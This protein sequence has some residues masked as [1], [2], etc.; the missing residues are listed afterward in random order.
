MS[1]PHISWLPWFALGATAL[2]TLVHADDCEGSRAMYDQ[3]RSVATTDPGLALRLL[4]TMTTQCP[5]AP[6]GWFL[7]GNMHRERGDHAAARRAYRQA[8][9]VADAPQAVEMARA[10]AALASFELGESCEAQ[11]TFRSLVPHPGEEVSDWLSDPW[12]AFARAMADAELSA[13]DIACALDETASDRTLGICPRVGL[14]IEFDYDSAHI[15]ADSRSRVE[16]LARA[17]AEHARSFRLVGHSDTRGDA[18]YNQTLSERRAQ[19]VRDAV[20]TLQGT[21]A[22][23]VDAIGKGE[24]EPLITARSEADHRVNRRVEVRVICDGST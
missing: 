14:R 8:A 6:H 15:R 19:S 17:L 2:A 23:R 16:A 1:R 7:A 24:R 4:D 11:R 10:Y 18:E 20:L 22:G 21:V 12:E 9:A 5:T 3:A 13:D